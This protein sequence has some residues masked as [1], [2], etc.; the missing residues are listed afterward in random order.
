MNSIEAL[1]LSSQSPVNQTI[2]TFNPKADAVTSKETVTFSALLTSVSTEDQISTN[3]QPVEMLDKL[4]EVLEGLQDMPKENLSPEEQEMMSAIIQLLFIQSLQMENKLQGA[5][6]PSQDNLLSGPAQ[7]NPMMTSP[8]IGEL[9]NLIQQIKQQLQEL[10]TSTTIQF[11]SIPELVGV[12][13][14]N[15][16]EDPLKFEQA[17]KQLVAFIQH[18]ETEQSA[19][20][21]QVSS[22]Q[23]EKMEQVLKH[24][25]SLT[26]ELESQDQTDS[27]KKNR[28]NIDLTRPISSVPVQQLVDGTPQL[29]TVQ[30]EGNSQSLTAGTPTDAKTNQALHRTET[31][32][33]TQTVRMSNLIEDLG[34]VLNG[35]LRLNGA[36]EDTQIKVSIFPEHLGHLEIRLTELNGKIAAQIFTS[37]LLAKEA[38]DLHVNQLRNSLLQQGITVDKIEISQQSSQQSFGQQ[39]ANPEQRFTQQHQRQG[40][41]RDKNGY[42]RIEDE[43]VAE[44]SH[45]V[46]GMMKVDYTV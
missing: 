23:L 26:Q 34:G 14:E 9:L 6:E 24:L 7:E 46:D 15:I 38:L 45:T 32:A 37:S 19:T 28:Q 17:N 20:G 1:K 39:N 35:S 12:E 13:G 2:K 3:N 8:I 40:M 27:Q 10:S 25:T 36:Q 16:L 5:K 31:S 29:E 11:E 4:E 22:L 18:L 41:S 44:R 33:L 30:H 42:Q 21:K 43:I